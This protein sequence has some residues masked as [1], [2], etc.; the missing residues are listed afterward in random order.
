[1]TRRW[2]TEELPGNAWDPEPPDDED[3]D[4]GPYCGTVIV[5]GDVL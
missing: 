4:G 1:M 5:K 2:T 3:D